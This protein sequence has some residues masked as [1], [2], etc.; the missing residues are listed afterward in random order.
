MSS[1]GRDK[2]SGGETP[3]DLRR[4]AARVRQLVREMGNDREAAD[5]LTELARDL[6]TRADAIEAGSRGRT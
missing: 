5:R 4:R 2:Q 3:A 1:G 6:E